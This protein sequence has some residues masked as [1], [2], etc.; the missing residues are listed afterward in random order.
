MKTSTQQLSSAWQMSLL[1]LFAA[2]VIMIP[3]LAFATPALEANDTVIGSSLC[4]V[5]GW[6]TGN[7][8]KGIA[9]IAI[10][11]IGVGALMGKVSW[12][13]AIIV[14]IGVALIFGAGSMVSS[15][16]T[17]GGSTEACEQIHN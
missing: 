7:T 5:V 9:T 6:F 16:G 10:I 13:M 15:I 12:G 4:K 1:M 14:G 2:V 3:D 17:G 11:V 8:G